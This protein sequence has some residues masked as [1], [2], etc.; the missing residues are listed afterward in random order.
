MAVKINVFMTSVLG[1]SWRTTVLGFVGAVFVLLSQGLT[2]KSAIIAVGVQMFGACVKDQW[3]H[4]TPAQ[5]QQA[6]ADAAK[7]A[8]N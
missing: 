6:G 8:K 2:L 5:V 7:A 1:A 3:A 4:S